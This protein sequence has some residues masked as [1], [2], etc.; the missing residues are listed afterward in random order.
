MI[1]SRVLATVAAVGALASLA[2]GCFLFPTAPEAPPPPGPKV[3]PPAV[4][5]S[6]TPA[7]RLIV[8][9]ELSNAPSR[10]IVLYARVEAKVNERLHF[11]PAQMHIVFSGQRRG[12]IFDPPRAAV[13][14]EQTELASWD[15]G[16]PAQSP[17]SPNGIDKEFRARLKEKVREA[18]MF[19][20]DLDPE[21]ALSGYLVVDAGAPVTSLEDAA[22]EVVTTRVRDLKEF[23]TISQFAS[24][25]ALEY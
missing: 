25:K 18:L 16:S 14:L 1:R 11:D 13:L 7:F 19:P 22:L 17:H 20:A 15:V 21:Q 2:T 9:P 4:T 12:E 3:L 10:L 23:R 5:V 6:A 8:S 24:H